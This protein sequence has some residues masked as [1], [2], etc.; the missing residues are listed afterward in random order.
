M[1]K[2]STSE[3]ARGKG[4]EVR[5]KRVSPER[6]EDGANSSLGSEIVDLRSPHIKAA[7]IN[8]LLRDH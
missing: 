3:R 4:L 6:I 8:E 7:L 1:P 5:V 2:R